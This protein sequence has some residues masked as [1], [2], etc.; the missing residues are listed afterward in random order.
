MVLASDDGEGVAN[1]TVDLG[2]KSCYDRRVK[3]LG[4]NVQSTCDTIVGQN[5]GS[6]GQNQN[7][8]ES[9]ELCMV[10]TEISS[11]DEAGD[12]VE[13]SCPLLDSG[14][15]ADDDIDAVVGKSKVNIADGRRE[16][17]NLAEEILRAQDESSRI[18]RSQINKVLMKWRCA[19]NRTRRKF[20]PEGG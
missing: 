10:I 14:T 16:A 9:G 3:S 13:V 8:E 18:S 4:A 15:T 12:L 11:D 17:N 1:A 6:S 7:I 2:N 19:K 5:S 20:R